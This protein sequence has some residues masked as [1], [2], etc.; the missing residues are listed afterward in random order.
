MRP[1]VRAARLLRVGLVAAAAMACASC[2]AV[3]G[4]PDAVTVQ[5]Q[6]L[7]GLW[8]VFVY[9]GIGVGAIVY[10]LIF[11]CVFRYRARGPG[12]PPQF[13]YHIPIEIT[14]VTLPVLLVIGL[15]II[16]V[17]VEKYVDYVAPVTKG[18][19]TVHVTAFRWSWMFDYVGT[20]VAV[21]GT[22]AQPPTAPMPIGQ[23]IHIVLT[24]ADVVHGFWVPD[25]LYKR[26]ATP[27]LVQRFQFTIA[28]PGLYLGECME[29]CG[30]DH[31]RM[32]FYIR[33]VPAAQFTAWLHRREAAQAHTRRAPTSASARQVSRP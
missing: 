18:D 17:R 13:R 22:P 10:G 1:R 24:S 29:F 28:K 19:L 23:P 30:F 32:R 4:L 14:Y 9:A 3:P 26:D 11:W 5:S 2:A 27:G 25:F 20:G 8:T 16:T 12:L 33:A 7:Y 15:F 31:T 6:S 21:V